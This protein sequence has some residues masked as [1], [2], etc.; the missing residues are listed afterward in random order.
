MDDI[1][2]IRGLGNVLPKNI[3]LPHTFAKVIEVYNEGYFIDVELI[4]KSDGLETYKNIAVLKN[5]YF[6]TPI[7]KDDI[8]I[9]I[10]LSHLTNDFLESGELENP[11]PMQS[12]LALPYVLK[13][14][15]ENQEFKN[16]FYL[17][18]P[19]NKVKIDI[20]ENV[21]NIDAKEA[22][23]SLNTNEL[24]IV[25]KEPISFKT[26]EELGKILSDLINILSSAQ[27]EIGGGGGTPHIHKSIDSSSVA[28]LNDIKNRLS[29]VLK[30]S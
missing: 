17:R 29:Q 19:K 9:L 12:Y 23:T 16:F 15:F 2:F 7:L 18:T 22:E 4:L 30:T 10:T 28:S 21:I 14:D 5:K 26:N 6:N 3:S 27:T 20:T 11:S 1:F 8:V 25:S 24:N 13:K